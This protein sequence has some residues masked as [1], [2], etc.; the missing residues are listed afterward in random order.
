MDLQLTGKRALVTGGSK[1]MT[2]AA[3]LALAH[4]GVDVAICARGVEELRR[5]E[6]ELQAVGKGRVLAVQADLAFPTDIERFVDL[7]RKKFGGIDIFLSNAGNPPGPYEDSLSFPDDAWHQTYNQILMSVVRIARLVVPE[8]RERRWGR[9]ITIT[10]ISVKQPLQQHVLSTCFRVATLAF[11]KTLATELAPQGITCNCVLPGAIRTPRMIEVMRKGASKGLTQAPFS[12]EQFSTLL[13]QSH[14][15]AATPSMEEA[16]AGWV[17][18]IPMGRVGKPEEVADLIAFL[19]S[20][21]AGYMTG[22]AIQ[23]DGGVVKCLF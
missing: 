22:T 16:E 4:E 23:V 17:K 9:I 13:A 15:A 6:Q 10:T 14:P 3:A 5:T 11:T 1:G 21:R 19:C 7:T 12:A 18:E 2:K 8:M 20:P